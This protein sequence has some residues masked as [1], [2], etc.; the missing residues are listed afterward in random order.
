MM[1]RFITRTLAVTLIALAGCDAN[2]SSYSRPYNEP[3]YRGSGRDY[4]YE[5]RRDE[6]YRRDREREEYRHD[7]REW[8]RDRERRERGERERRER[9]ENDHRR[10]EERQAPPPPRVEEH[11]PS[12]F[13]P[14]E[15]KCSSDERR[16]GCKDVRL[17]GGLGCVRR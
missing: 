14:S 13:Q 15:R 5:R 12:G 11:C 9:E 8:E 1:R 7:K 17:P 3:Y 2:D 6:E 10:H 4:D 16:H